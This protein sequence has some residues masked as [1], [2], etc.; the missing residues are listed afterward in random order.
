MSAAGQ[1]AT[2]PKQEWWCNFCNYKTDDQSAYIAHSCAEE[3]KKQGKAPTATD[4]KHC[5]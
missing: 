1:P 2:A 4:K 3:L 5:G